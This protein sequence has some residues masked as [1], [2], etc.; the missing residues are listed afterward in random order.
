MVHFLLGLLIGFFIIIHL[1]I[2]HLFSSINS[3]FNSYSSL[4]IPFYS[5][6]YNDLLNQSILS[7]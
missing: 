2:I 3:I 6:L 1:F 7:T 5:I 4:L